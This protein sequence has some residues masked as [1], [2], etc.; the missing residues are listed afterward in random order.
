VQLC[1]PHACKRCAHVRSCCSF[2]ASCDESGSIP[3]FMLIVG[4]SCSVGRGRHESVDHALA[5]PIPA[6]ART[7]GAAA[8]ELLCCS[9]EHRTSASAGSISCKSRELFQIRWH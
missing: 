7:G 2:V 6:M 3:H 1:A 9:R 8:V 4:F 5:H